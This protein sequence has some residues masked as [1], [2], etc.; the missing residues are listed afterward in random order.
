[1]LRYCIEMSAARPRQTATVNLLEA[2]SEYAK[3][4]PTIIVATKDDFE[5]SRFMEARKLYKTQYSDAGALDKE[6]EDYTAESAQEHAPH[7][8]LHSSGKGRKC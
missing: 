4:V 6:C 1:M 7:K 3:D 2:V 8:H 5:G